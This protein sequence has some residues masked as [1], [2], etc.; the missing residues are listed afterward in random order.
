MKI[1]RYNGWCQFRSQLMSTSPKRLGPFQTI[2]NF[3]GKDGGFGKLNSQGKAATYVGLTTF[4][5]AMFGVVAKLVG[6]RKVYREVITS[7][8]D[9]E[10]GG[11]NI[12]SVYRRE[13]KKERERSNMIGNG[14]GQ[15]LAWLHYADYLQHVL[16]NIKNSIEQSEWYKQLSP[17]ERL[18]MP[19]KLYELIPRKCYLDVTGTDDNIQL[20]AEIAIAS[21]KDASVSKKPIKVKIYSIKDGQ[22]KYYFTCNCP[23]ELTTMNNVNDIQKAGISQS[24]S[25]KYDFSWN[26]KSTVQHF[27]VDTKLVQLMRFYY[28]LSSLLCL[29][30]TKKDYRDKVRLILFNESDKNL[31]NVLLQAVKED[32]KV[33]TSE[34]KLN[35]LVMNMKLLAAEYTAGK[36]DFDVLVTNSEQAFENK[37]G[38]LTQCRMNSGLESDNKKLKEDSKDVISNQKTHRSLME[39]KLLSAEE[40][41]DIFYEYDVFVTRRKEAHDKKWDSKT[42]MK[43]YD[44]KGEVMEVYDKQGKPMT[45]YDKEWQPL[46]VYDKE[47]KPTKVYDDKGKPMNVY[48]TI[49]EDINEELT[50]KNMKVL[51][52]KDCI[53]KDWLTRLKYAATKCRWIVFM[54]TNESYGEM[55]NPD[56]LADS[57]KRILESRTFLGSQKIANFLKSLL[58][59][60]N[61]F[62]SQQVADS[63]KSILE[64]RMVQTVAVVNKENQLRVLDDLRWVTCIPFQENTNFMNTL[65][66]VVSGVEIN[67][68]EPNEIHFKPGEVAV[69]LAWAYAAN[70]LNKLLPI[71][72][73]EVKQAKKQLNIPLPDYPKLY[74]FVPESCETKEFL[75]EGPPEHRAKSYT[76]NLYEK[77]VVYNVAKDNMTP[78]YFVGEYARPVE[79]IRQ[80]N[81]NKLLNKEQMKSE[82]E[83]FYTTVDKI[84]KI[85]L[86][87]KTEN[88]EFVY[89]NDA[90][91]DLD[92]A[93]LK[94]ISE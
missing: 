30:P 16:P 36:Y 20:E 93:L 40:N 18:R 2:K 72:G 10:D 9:D 71:V 25:T 5:T 84:M 44:K 41:K 62:A 92:D 8:E 27:T 65:Y 52:E 45:V 28:T 82:V 3:F 4:V 14:V 15:G 22:T 34:K 56:K 58:A 17:E 74:I 59:S 11:G 78:V 73:E 53:G 77:L 42:A 90:K 12:L 49:M 91:T 57:H 33:D 55:S 69:G 51:L 47:K 89:F 37:R 67:L 63:L 85:L 6:I 88:Y 7:S 29:K 1:N 64:S 76:G 48:A 54:D 43:V 75:S 19:M 70:H 21:K 61:L 23:N 13:K 68:E 32:L 38:K 46:T 24:K 50:A 83:K 79:V 81:K 26:R 94:K 60:K 87:E 39:K 80:M 35:G 66:K 86:P 31:S